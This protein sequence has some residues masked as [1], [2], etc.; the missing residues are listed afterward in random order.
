[1]KPPQRINVVGTSGS[2]KSTFCRQLAGQLD[3]PHV[4]MDA[5]YWGPN[6]TEPSDEVFFKKLEQQLS[7][8]RWVLDGNYTRT[9]PVK[10]RRVQTI[11]WLDYSFPR[12]L[13]QTLKRA[14]A[15]AYTKEEL[16]PGTNNRESFR[17]SFFSRDSIVL[18]SITSFSKVRR[19]YQ[20]IV[21]SGSYPQIEF[22]RLCSP[23]QTKA[24]LEKLDP[25]I[26]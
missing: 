10:W 11:I 26:P 3:A 4:E 16:W 24:Y 5:V 7:G 14:I 18:W 17:K 19:S 1:M 23:S 13:Y 8:D 12:T 21:E 6:W 20:Q 25:T 9:I 15:R 2:G 22:V